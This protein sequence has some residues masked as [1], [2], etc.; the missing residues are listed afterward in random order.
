MFSNIVKYTYIIYA[1]SSEK[2]IVCA[3]SVNKIV[4][5]IWQYSA[6]SYSVI[7]LTFI[8]LINQLIE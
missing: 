3:I 6:R 4:V 8:Y 7:N 1:D 5:S 2:C